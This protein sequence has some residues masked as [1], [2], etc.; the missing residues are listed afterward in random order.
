MA[1]TP[2][3]KQQLKSRAHSL[4]PV[5]MIGNHGLTDAVMLEVERGLHDHE[6]IKIKVASNDRDAR[7]EILN[8]IAAKSEAELVQVIGGIGVFYRPR[9]D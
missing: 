3:Q 1:L 2:K 9:E 7:R 5:V 8:Q 6:L 4:K